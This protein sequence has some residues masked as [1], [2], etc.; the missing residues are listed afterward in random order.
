[1]ILHNLSPKLNLLLDSIETQL[2]TRNTKLVTWFKMVKLPNLALYFIPLFKNS[3]EYGR[4]SVAEVIHSIFFCAAVDKLTDRISCPRFTLSIP[5]IMG[6]L[7][8]LSYSL[9]SMDRLHSIASKAGVEQEFL[10]YY[11]IKKAESKNLLTMC[12]ED[13]LAADYRSGRQA[14]HGCNKIKSAYM[15]YMSNLKIHPFIKK[16]EEKDIDVEILVGSLES[17]VNFPR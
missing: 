5:E 4:S 15:P 7:I 14:Y 9:V 8:D 13:Y 10:A 17:P 6:K 2:N 16:F 11:Q 12:L 1:M 3:L